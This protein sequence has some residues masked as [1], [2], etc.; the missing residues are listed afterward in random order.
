MIHPNCI[1]CG[2]E[3]EKSGAIIWG[4]PTVELGRKQEQCD[5][6]HLCTICYKEVMLFIDSE[7]EFPEEIN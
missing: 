7:Y 1:K 2:V 3:L 5:K 6:N 4:Y